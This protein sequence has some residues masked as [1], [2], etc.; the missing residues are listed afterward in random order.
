MGRLQATLYKTRR[1][2]A[3]HPKNSPLPWG[4]VLSLLAAE[5]GGQGSCYWLTVGAARDPT[6]HGTAHHNTYLA[7]SVQGVKAE[8]PRD[9]KSWILLMERACA[10]TPTGNAG[11][12][13]GCVYVCNFGQIKLSELQ[14]LCP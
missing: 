10:G 4:T 3:T 6:I 5:L 7:P 12:D 8:K 14:F 9:R 2:V 13:P 11:S 1:T